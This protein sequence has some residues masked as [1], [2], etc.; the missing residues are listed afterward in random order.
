MAHR[1]TRSGTGEH[2]ARRGVLIGALIFPSSVSQRNHARAARL[3][4]NGL[5]WCRDGYSAEP[6][7]AF[8]RDESNSA[9]VL[10]ERDSVSDR[11]NGHRRTFLT[12]QRA[13]SRM[14]RRRYRLPPK[15]TKLADCAKRARSSRR[16]NCVLQ[17]RTCTAHVKS[18]R[19]LSRRV[20]H[21]IRIMALPCQRTIG[22]HA[23]SCV[24]AVCGG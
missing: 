18:F 10:R 9:H 4:A 17:R 19:F 21:S 2:F 3:L 24:R 8:T 5:P 12:S 16:S 23:P 22:A 20:R 14:R 13:A 6:E 11:Y 15:S 7:D 1:S